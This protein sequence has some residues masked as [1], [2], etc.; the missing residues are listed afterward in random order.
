VRPSHRPLSPPPS[1]SAPV[2]LEPAW[3]RVQRTNCSTWAYL[4]VS[5]LWLL[6]LLL[7]LLLLFLVLLLLML[8]CLGQ[9]L[10]VEGALA[11]CWTRC[12]LQ[13]FCSLLRLLS[14]LGSRP[15]SHSQS[16]VRLFKQSERSCCSVA[17]RLT[18]QT[19]RKTTDGACG[20]ALR[21]CF[22]CGGRNGPK[23]RP[24]VCGGIR[25]QLASFHGA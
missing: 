16:F 9:S 7:L 23:L 17:V 18:G 25:A 13:S 19:H 1:V 5:K 12:G 6:L 21:A 14:A 3:H 10:V 15:S 24:S 2:A 20:V 11:C 4:V 22:A 8:L